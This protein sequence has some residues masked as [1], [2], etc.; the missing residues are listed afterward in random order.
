MCVDS[1][2][3]VQVTVPAHLSHTGKDRRARKPIDSCI[4]PIVRALNRAG[5]RTDASCC[6]HRKWP[7]SIVLFDGRIL[8]IEGLTPTTLSPLRPH[9]P[10]HHGAAP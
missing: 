2:G 5:I 7:G 9:L 4:A 1:T 3:L 8:I 6:G 10:P